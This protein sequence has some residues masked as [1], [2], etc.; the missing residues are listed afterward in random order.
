MLSFL[1]SLKPKTNRISPFPTI[2]KL[3]LSSVKVFGKEESSPLIS[4]SS[5]KMDMQHIP[6]SCWQIQII[7]QCYTKIHYTFSN[8]DCY[9]YPITTLLWNKLPPELKKSSP[10][11][12]SFEQLR[13]TTSN[14]DK[15]EP[16]LNSPLKNLCGYP[17]KS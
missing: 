17:S 6:A 4:L 1:S 5:L 9:R 7:L 15:V 14:L 10:C 3:S 2:S 16:H 8:V 13:K 11:V 12:L